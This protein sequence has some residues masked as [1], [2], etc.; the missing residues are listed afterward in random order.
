MA[1]GHERALVAHDAGVVQCCPLLVKRV[2][3]R[4]VDVRVF[5]REHAQLHAY[6][7]GA[8]LGGI[9]RH[10]QVERGAGG[11]N[12]VD[13][14]HVG[15]A[16][17]AGQVHG[18]RALLARGGREHDALGLAGLLG[19]PCGGLGAHAAFEGFRHV[20]RHFL[21]HGL[22]LVARQRGDVQVRRVHV[23]LDGAQDG[24]RVGRRFGAGRV[25]LGLQAG[26]GGVERVRFASK[27]VGGFHADLRGGLKALRQL[28]GG[29]VH[30]KA[31]PG[32]RGHRVHVLQNVGA[33]YPI[34]PSISSL[35]RLFISTAY[36]SG[37]SFDTGSAK[38]FTIMV[39]ASSSEIP[40]L[41]R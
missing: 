12:H 6:H 35:M 18:C 9:K 26:N 30:V 11:G 16:V 31:M 3:G 4:D 14:S 33:H 5:A 36:S 22:V 7:A 19:Q 17:H 8:G 25:H 13:G 28:D 24:A 34:A 2:H 15:R 1:H 38:P 10:R 21:A 41:I 39:R 29:F 23:R 27:L 32:R 40:R 37:S 20:V